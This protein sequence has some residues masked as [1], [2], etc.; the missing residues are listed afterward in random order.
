MVYVFYIIIQI[1]ISDTNSDWSDWTSFIVC[2]TTAQKNVMLGLRQDGILV[3][4]CVAVQIFHSMCIFVLYKIP[5]EL[6]NVLS[7]AFT[8][9]HIVGLLMYLWKI[10]ILD[11]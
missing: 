1:F 8:H 9:T 3:W 7:I 4:I 11:T 5:C 2:D 6:A 10:G